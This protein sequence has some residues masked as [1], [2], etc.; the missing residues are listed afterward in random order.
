MKRNSFKGQLLLVSLLI[1]LSITVSAGS[2]G[3]S[4]I[5]ALSE[6]ECKAMMDTGLM[7]LAAPVPCDRLKVLT[8]RYI[9]FQGKKHSD[10]RLLVM[11]AVAPY[12]S[13]IVS[14]LYQ[15]DF[16]LH[17]A[18]TLQ[19][20]QGDDYLS[21]ADNNTSAFNYRP[22]AGQDS[23]S[24]HA[25]GLAIDINPE[26][27][28]SIEFKKKGTVY[29][30]PKGFRHSNRMKYR[31]GKKDA[32]GYAEEIVHVFAKNGFQY[33]GG[34]WDNPIDYQHF[35]VSRE[36]ARLMALMDSHTAS[37][38]FKRYVQWY[39]VCNTQYAKQYSQHKFRDY[40]D[41]LKTRLAVSHLD[42]TFHQEPSKMKLLLGI[43]PKATE[44][45]I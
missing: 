45:C 34:F 5:A 2:T 43:V 38:F 29:S 32:I 13:N 10:G 27:N 21:M 44:A 28:P 36:M 18:V 11:D 16:P 42:K 20:Y 19:P 41:Y 24:I 8:F 37:L 35:Q 30:P 33:W 9:D 39:S 12:V 3:W 17:K 31:A 6:T 15:L 1:S 4:E 23:L 26:Q 22:I 25:Y 40:V 14:E 7:D